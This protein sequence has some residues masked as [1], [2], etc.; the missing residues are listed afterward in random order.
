[1]NITQLGDETLRFSNLMKYTEVPKEVRP[2][3]RITL[4]T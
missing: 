1:M 2:S 3:L 4:G